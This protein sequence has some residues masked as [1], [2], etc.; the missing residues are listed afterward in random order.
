MLNFDDIFVYLY[1]SEKEHGTEYCHIVAKASFNLNTFKLTI[2]EKLDKKVE[3]MKAHTEWVPVQRA[4]E[5]Y[6]EAKLR[7][8]YDLDI[9]DNFWKCIDKSEDNLYMRSKRHVGTKRY[10]VEISDE[11]YEQLK[12][13]GYDRD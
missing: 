9:D 7:Y 8:I 4:K 13:D 1:H 3:L 11:E 6:Y 5:G 12:G 2:V 10:L